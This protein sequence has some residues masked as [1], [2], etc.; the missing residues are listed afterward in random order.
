MGCSYCVQPSCSRPASHAAR[1][2]R[3]RPQFASSPPCQARQPSP[4]VLLAL[5]AVRKDSSSGSSADEEL[6]RAA[7]ERLAS[8]AAVAPEHPGVSRDAEPPWGVNQEF[9]LALNKLLSRMLR[10][11]LNDD[12]RGARELSAEVESLQV[13]FADPGAG[14]DAGTARFLRCLLEILAR[15][16]PA[17]AQVDALR[18][19]YELA[20]AKLSGLLE[21][22]DWELQSE[23]DQPGDTDK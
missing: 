10:V 2:V 14:N 1:Q 11:L 23:E 18:P 12:S 3:E 20:L 5:R 17:R 21:H 9:K 7:L 4:R 16:A 15:R 19:D 13:H 22:S 8:L 6:S